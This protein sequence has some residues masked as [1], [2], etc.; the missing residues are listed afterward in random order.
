MNILITG[1]KGILGSALFKI[2]SPLNNVIPC[3]I[4][5]FDI[6]DFEKASAFIAARK[7]DIIINCAAYTD[8]DGCEQNIEQA[9]L[10]NGKGTE[11]IAII[12]KQLDIP[13]VQI[14]TDY[15]FDGRKDKPYLEDDPVNPLSIYGKSKLAG[16]EAVQ[17]TLEKFYI[18]RTSWLFGENGK[19]FVDT[20][21]KITKEKDELRVVNDQSGSPTYAVDLAKAISELIKTTRYGIYHITNQGNCSWYEFTK[22]ILDAA[23]MKNKTVIPVTTDEFPR[24]APRPKNS[25]L[26]NR[27]FKS[28]GFNLPRHYKEAVEEYITLK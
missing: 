17:K 27:L 5:D 1:A 3:G 19:N 13:I 2:L 15:V 18:V 24:P 11:N 16:E 14:S 21:L 7:P 6:T 26:E 25:I 28:I 10:V 23:N 20:I 4:D 8:V 12:C 9:F 22:V